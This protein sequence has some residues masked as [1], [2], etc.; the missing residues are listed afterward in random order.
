MAAPPRFKALR[1]EDLQDNVPKWGEQL[2]LAWN[3]TI[4]GIANALTRRLTRGDN[5]LAGERIGGTFRTKATAA[6]T[7]PIE[8]KNELPFPPRH[9]CVSK[10]ERVDGSD[11]TTAWSMTW[12][13]G[14]SNLIQLSFQGLPASTEFRFSILY[15]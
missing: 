9:V 2:L 3:E 4:G 5:F 7:W 8:V 11:I 1:P 15:E 12:R 6:D 10:L 13:M 14:A